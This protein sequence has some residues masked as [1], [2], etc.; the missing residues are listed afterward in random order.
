[1]AAGLRSDS[2]D[3]SIPSSMMSSSMAGGKSRRRR[4][5]RRKSSRRK[6]RKVRR[7]RKR[8]GSG[9]NKKGGFSQI[10]SDAIVPFGLVALNNR[11]HRKSAKKSRA[12]S[13]R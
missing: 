1:M 3:N 5:S 13:R 2:P 12:R 10:I 8:G 11:K 4:A 6:S 7:S 9:C